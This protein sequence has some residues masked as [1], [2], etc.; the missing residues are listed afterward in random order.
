MIELCVKE[1]CHNCPG[2]TPETD[3]YKLFADDRSAE[4][5]TKIYC[6]Y[7]ARCANIAR[8]LEKEIERKHADKQQFECELE[9]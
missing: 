4:Y 7:A 6:K 1:Y 9:D 5:S 8:Y 3:S 2:F